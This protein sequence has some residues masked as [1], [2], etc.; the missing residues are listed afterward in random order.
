MSRTN[1]LIKQ[2][3]SY[4]GITERTESI[5]FVPSKQGFYNY[6]GINEAQCKFY[7]DYTE[8]IA[9]KIKDAFESI[10]LLLDH[11]L[12]LHN[13]NKNRCKKRQKTLDKVVNTLI[14][15]YGWFDAKDAELKSGNKPSKFSKR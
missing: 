11:L 15:D 9:R 14:K 2:I 7:L 3:E 5:Y 13:D 4:T 6:V 10:E 1:K 8:R 12:H